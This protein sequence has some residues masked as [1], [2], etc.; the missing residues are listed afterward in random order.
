MPSAKSILIT[1]LIA[2]A[3]VAV[4]VRVPAAKTIVFGG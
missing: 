2:L 3:F 1:G 4:V